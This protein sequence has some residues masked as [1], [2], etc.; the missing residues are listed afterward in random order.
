[1]LASGSCKITCEH[2]RTYPHT[3]AQY[4]YR[5]SS[6]EAKSLKD[7]TVCNMGRYFM[8]C[9]FFFNIKFFYFSQKFTLCSFFHSVG[10]F[11]G[12]FFPLGS[13]CITH[14]WTY[15]T[16]WD[17]EKK[18]LQPRWN[19]STFLDRKPN[20]KWYIFLY[21]FKWNPIFCVS[22]HFLA[23]RTSTGIHLSFFLSIGVQLRF[24]KVAATTRTLPHGNP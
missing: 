1:M 8:G 14:T 15:T 13:N 16:Q 9:H 23:R 17:G 24:R 19:S 21:G 3:D 6:I 12:L 5:E 4:I 22:R 18:K 11:F 2:V 20:Q 10:G 7:R